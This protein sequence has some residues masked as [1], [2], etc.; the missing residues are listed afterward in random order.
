MSFSTVYKFINWKC[1][2]FFHIIP[3]CSFAYMHK[4]RIQSLFYI[5]EYWPK[6]FWL[7]EF[8]KLHS[9]A[10]RKTSVAELPGFTL[11]F[12]YS[13]YELAKWFVKGI[14]AFLLLT[15]PPLAHCI[16]I[17]WRVVFLSKTNKSQILV[18]VHKVNANNLYEQFDEKPYNLLG[19]SLYEIQRGQ[20]L[21]ERGW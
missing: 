13:L 4:L 15:D 20:V 21:R 2:N 12:I 8:S 6:S 19:L 14:Q 17:I 1:Y 10:T 11:L 16:W 5:S 7:I 3:V 18:Y 9:S